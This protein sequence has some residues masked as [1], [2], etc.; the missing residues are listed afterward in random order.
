M[1]AACSITEAMD[2]AIVRRSSVW[3]AAHTKEPCM[4][5]P[6]FLSLRVS[7]RGSITIRNKMGDKREP[8]FTPL[9]I[10]TGSLNFEPTRILL[11][12]D[13][14]QLN[15]IRQQFPFTPMANSLFSRMLNSIESKAFSRSKRQRYG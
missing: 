2:G 8:Y 6:A 12:A 1:I 3:A 11:K 13:E 5:S 7:S 14:Y 4:E 15:T 10:E 9:V